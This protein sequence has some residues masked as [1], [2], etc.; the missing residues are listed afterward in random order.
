MLTYAHL[1]AWKSSGLDDASIN[2]RRDIRVLER[3]CDKLENKA[4]PV[5]WNGLA[6]VKAELKRDGLVSRMTDHLDDMRKLERA[7]YTAAD[8]VKSLRT[9]IEDI[10]TD[11]S[12]QQFSISA[13]GT[14]SDNAPP[15]T[16]DNFIDA[17]RY[18]LGRMLLRNDLADRIGNLIDMADEIDGD[19]L[20]ARPDGSLGQSGAPG[21]TDPAVERAWESMSDEERT[22][23]LKL[24]A[25]DLADSY[26]LGDFEVEI[27]DLEDEDGDGKDDDPTT[28]LF[29]DWNESKKRL[30]LDLNDLHDPHSLDTMAHEVRHAAQY[31]NIRRQNPPWWTPWADPKPP[32]PGV[33]EAEVERW[34]V[35]FDDYKTI[36]KDGFDAYRDQAV[37]VDARKYGAKYVDELSGDDFEDYRRRAR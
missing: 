12:A 23:V 2:L 37:E 10:D 30:R 17:T 31:E 24:M 15:P 19:L 1:R 36:D 21:K 8:R 26:G 18:Q 27:T 20:R 22:K 25:R 32:T 7:F 13:D 28:N 14:V 4:I 34:R 6:K 11:A 29:G 5:S 35:N 16:F 33:S 3:A 9:L